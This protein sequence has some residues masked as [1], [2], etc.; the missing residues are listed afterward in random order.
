MIRS[1]LIK[2]VKK[3]FFFFKNGINL[4][5]LNDITEIVIHYVR[6][7]ALLSADVT[8]NR[9]SESSTSIFFWKL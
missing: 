1:F 7:Y 3:S 6:N 2:S 5:D 9:K 8:T 4:T